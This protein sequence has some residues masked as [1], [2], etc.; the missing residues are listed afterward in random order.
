MYNKSFYKLSFSG[1]LVQTE[2]IFTTAIHLT[3]QSGTLTP[4]EWNALTDGRVARAFQAFADFWAKP[5]ALV[6]FPWLLETVKVAWIGTDGK[7]INE[8]KEQLFPPIN[9]AMGDA[10]YAAQLALATNVVSDKWKDPGK[11]NRMYIPTVGQVA[12]GGTLNSTQQQAYLEAFIIF[13][14]EI[15]EIFSEVN[16][17]LVVSVMSSTSSGGFSQPAVAARV[18]RVIDTQRRRRNKLVEN[19][20][21]LPL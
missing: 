18:G 15:N 2:E 19:Y 17:S 16:P 6:P 14:N 10:R 13:I 12:D 8:P 21:D 5:A 3:T 9:G 1:S 7:Y 4:V 11:Y 20:L